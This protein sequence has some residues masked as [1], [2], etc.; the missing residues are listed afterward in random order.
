MGSMSPRCAHSPQAG[1]ILSAAAFVLL[2]SLASTVEA[3]PSSWAPVG[4]LPAARQ[5]HV[6]VPLLDGRV[7]IVGQDTQVLLFDP[8]TASFSATGTG[9]LYAHG[10]G[11]RAA[12]LND[13]RVLIV[14]GWSTGLKAEIFDPVSGTFAP[15]ANDLSRP[16][17]LHTLTLLGDGRVLVAG[18]RMAEPAASEI[19]TAEI[20]DPATATF[21]PTG[22]LRCGRDSHAAA[23]LSDGRVLVMGGS[24][25]T[26]PG[27]G[28]TLR[29]AELFDPAIGTFTPTGSMSFSRTG[30]DAV[31]L[32][33]GTVLVFGWAR[34]SAE[35]YDPASGRFRETGGPSVA[36][37]SATATP[38]LDGRVL[39]SGGYKAVGPVTTPITELYW[40]DRNAFSRT[41]SMGQARQQHSAAR[42]LDGRVLVSGGTPGGSG[43]L[44]SAEVF[45]LGDETAPFPVTL[46]PPVPGGRIEGRIVDATTGLPIAGVF[47]QLYS[48]TGGGA[49]FGKTNEN[50]EYFGDTG[51]AAGSYYVVTSNTLGYI[52]QVYGGGACAGCDPTTGIPVVVAAE[53]TTGGV[54]FSLSP[55]PQIRGTV[56]GADTGAGLPWVWVEI[57]NA[58]GRTVSRVVTDSSGAY[59][60]G[61]GLPPGNY[62]VRTQG[63]NYRD[64]LYPDVPCKFGC[65][66]LTGG[67]VTV[68]A[69]SA[70][71]VDF[72]LDP[73]ATISGAVV[74]A[75]TAA[76]L[77]GITIELWDPSG[78]MLTS[79]TTRPEPE[80]YSFHGLPD[81]SYYFRT[82]NSLG[83]VNQVYAGIPCLTS[84]SAV[85]GTAV[86]VSAGGSW[87]VDFSL[88]LDTDGDGDGIFT[89][90]DKNATTS[91]DESTVPSNDFS[92]V[93]LGGTTVGTLSDR[94]GW[95]VHVQ[96]LGPWEGVSATLSGSGTGP[97]TLDVCPDGDP[98]RVILDAASES[99]SLTCGYGGS[100][101]ALALFAAPLIQLRKPLTGAGIVVDLPTAHAAT[102]GSPVTAGWQN[103][104]AIT[105]RFVDGGG[106]TFGSFA[107]DAGESVDAR[108]ASD[109]TAQAMVLNGTVT[110]EVRGEVVTLRAGESRV[111][112]PPDATPPVITP[113][114]VG[115]LG[116]NGWY[117]SDIHVSWTVVDGESAVSATTGCGPTDV[118]AD[119]PG[120]VLTCTATS[121]G[122]SSTASVTLKRDATPP[123]IVGTRDPGPGAGGW[124]NTDVLVTFTCSDALSGV[125]SCTPPQ[126]VTS[127]GAGQSRTGWARDGAGNQARATVAGIA[128]DKHGPVIFGMPHHCVLWPADGRLVEVATVTAHDHLAGLLG[129]LAVSVTSDEPVGGGRHA[130][131][132][133][134]RP[135][136]PNRVSIWLRRE[137]LPRGDG[138]SY[139]LRAV[140]GDLAGNQTAQ[141]ATCS[142]PHHDGG[143]H[144]H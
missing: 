7:L 72:V 25:Q 34:N 51:L 60:E 131:D 59:A 45:T 93:P 69:G 112:P 116:S 114:V 113:H 43:T 76:R 96:D 70:P 5:D 3:V 91:A 13:G 94:G 41:V 92:D 124:N 138:R 84:C 4:A 44:S 30:H 1:R 12:R 126:L 29:S 117:V 46:G 123:I 19:A 97:A 129:A 20:F 85:S 73:G 53:T 119:S 66:Y 10:F 21:A 31:T 63:S 136:G 102:L 48:S 132:W 15:T 56:T 28:M 32:P 106:A 87:A 137:R 67:A 120:F 23:L 122:G 135:Q 38:L 142:V 81:G 16:H 86:T 99:A 8:S 98:E 143:T 17:A 111:F 82:S 49:G 141:N 26:Q 61:A 90:V 77:G 103:I 109:G 14:G 52:D 39:V 37:D 100:T 108:V 121:A 65:D 75:A 22:S 118:T 88:S 105:V 54:D 104:D 55:G 27:Y 140:A 144:R 47:V 139:T 89:T 110:I 115:T 95:T 11:V 74:D 127:D 78:R 133:V 79:W 130:P 33:D 83:Y 58:S 68:T 40:P 128:I 35:I 36:H 2:V 107:L 18:G 9:A 24:V 6:S 80:A 71:T 125:S 101:T 42:L 134:I 64:E 57:L 62:Y 50:G